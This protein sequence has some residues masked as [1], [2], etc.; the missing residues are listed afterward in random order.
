MFASLKN[1][2][3]KEIFNLIKWVSIYIIYEQ[4][5]LRIFLII[6]KINLEYFLPFK[7]I[8]KNNQVGNCLVVSVL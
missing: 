7:L 4:S 6:L 8:E 3:S 5:M 2:E 1:L